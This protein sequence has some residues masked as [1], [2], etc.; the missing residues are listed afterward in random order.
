MNTKGLSVFEQVKNCLSENNIP[1]ENI[2][3]CATDGAASV[4]GQYR[5]FNA[6]LKR[7]KPSVFTTHCIIHRE[8]LVSKNLGGHLNILLSVV[9]RP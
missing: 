4:F 3:A 5:E 9:I 1:I 7:V 8:H 6:H 2:I